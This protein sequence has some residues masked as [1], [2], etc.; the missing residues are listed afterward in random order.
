[1]VGDERIEWIVVVEF[2]LRRDSRFLTRSARPPRRVHTDIGDVQI[3]HFPATAKPEAEEES[4]SE[5]GDGAKKINPPVHGAVTIVKEGV[6]LTPRSPKL[7]SSVVGPVLCAS[8][9]RGS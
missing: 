8:V 2:E 6:C 1:V 5:E 9:R 3:R 7:H 4:K